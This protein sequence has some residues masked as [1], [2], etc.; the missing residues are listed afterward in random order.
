MLFPLIKTQEH[1]LC[2]STKLGR[3]DHV[4]HCAP[5][6][7]LNVAL[8]RYNLAR[9]F[10]GTDHVSYVSLNVSINVFLNVSI[11]VFLNVSHVPKCG[12][13]IRGTHLGTRL[14]AMVVIIF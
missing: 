10:R 11:N 12:P 8:S 4:P 9:N 13:K 2:P 6:V 7:F 1:D 5:I 3:H 14:G